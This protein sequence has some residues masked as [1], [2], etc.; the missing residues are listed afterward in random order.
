[1]ADI[2]N[3][4]GLV[5]FHNGSFTFILQYTDTTSALDMFVISPQLL[6]DTTCII[7]DGPLG[8]DHFLIIISYTVTTQGEPPPPHTTLIKLTG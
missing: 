4:S 3:D 7:L 6:P 2:T 1:M 5:L 8:S